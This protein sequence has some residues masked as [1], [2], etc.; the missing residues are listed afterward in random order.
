MSRD[1][2]LFL[3]YIGPSMAGMLI[4]GSFCIVD[5]IFIGRGIGKVGLAAVALTWPLVMLLGAMGDMIGSG[6]AVIISQARGA[7]NPARAQKTF[8]NMISLLAAGALCLGVPMYLW[9]E[10]ILLLFGA[11]PELMPDAVPYAR[12]LIL[13]AFAG[14]FMTG[15]I[16]VVR[17]DGRPVLAMYLVVAGLLCNMFLDWMFIM[18]FNWGAPGAAWAT[19]ISQALSGTL[20]LIYFL[21]P[22]TEL[23]ID[24][25]NLRP[26]GGTVRDICVTGI[27]IFGNMLSIIAMLFMH[28]WQS[29]RYGGVDGLAAYTLVA[30]LESVGSLLMTGL[31]GG[32]QPLTAYLYGAG[33]RRRQNRI[34]NFGYW[35]AFVLGIA[36]MLFSFAFRDIMPGWVGLSGQVAELAARGVVL[37]APAFLLLGVIRVAGYYYQSTGKIADS[38]LLIYGDTFFALPLCLFVL[39]VWFGMDGVWLA[40]PISR[41]ILFGVLCYLWFGK[42]R[43]EYGSCSQTADC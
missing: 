41:V 20:G 5:T 6:A 27:P 8:G 37:S 35:T 36:L 28:N 24:R 2:R 30:G 4:A 1:V 19:V 14:M 16:A 40:M 7:G 39:P 25:R 15:C 9:L 17:N 21:S 22:R 32:V 29:L 18:V 3:R 33:K 43:K 10:P 38:S 26:D 42:R 31:A 13:G 23:S 12:I 11:T 34:G